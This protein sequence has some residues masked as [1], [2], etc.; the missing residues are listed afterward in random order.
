MVLKWIS[1]FVLNDL[2]YQSHRCVFHLR[3]MR[4]LFLSFS[5]QSLLAKKVAITACFIDL[6]CVTSFNI[7]AVDM[8]IFII[9]NHLD[10]KFN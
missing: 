6:L 10:I 7:I 4:N 1:A 8:I 2:E 3:P 9:N 5:A